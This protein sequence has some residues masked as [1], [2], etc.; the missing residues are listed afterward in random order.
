MCLYYQ[1]TQEAK[2]G[3]WQNC[4]THSK[5]ILHASAA[6]LQAVGGLQRATGNYKGM[7]LVYFP[8]LSEHAGT[9]GDRTAVWKACWG[10][11][12]LSSHLCH[13]KEVSKLLKT[14]TH[15]QNTYTNNT[16]CYE[17]WFV[18]FVSLTCVTCV[19]FLLFCLQN[20]FKGTYVAILITELVSFGFPASSKNWDYYYP[21]FG[22]YTSGYLTVTKFWYVSLMFF[23]FLM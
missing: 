19:F 2:A 7:L 13:I 21:Y 1:L 23:Q 17:G 4:K 20:T 15:T 22:K 5:V 12:S 10:Y 16:K 11:L 14:H 8:G 3:R 6:V 9:P 18:H